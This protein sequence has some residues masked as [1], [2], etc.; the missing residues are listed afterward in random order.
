MKFSK[1]H[2]SDL[3]DIDVS[4][5]EC[6]NAGQWFLYRINKANASGSFFLKLDHE[7]YALGKR[8]EVLSI[9]PAEEDI[10]MDE[11]LYFDDLPNP[12]S[13]SNAFISQ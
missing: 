7:I 3:P 13:L 9:H 1:I 5:K 8:G 11:A 2:S 12:I 6:V 10:E 4:V